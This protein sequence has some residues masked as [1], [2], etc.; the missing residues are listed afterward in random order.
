MRETL[1][2]ATLATSLATRLTD[3][4]LQSWIADGTDVTRTEDGLTFTFEDVEDA[5][6][7]WISTPGFPAMHIG[8]FEDAQFIVQ[9]L[10]QLNPYTQDSTWRYEASDKRKAA[11]NA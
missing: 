8:G 1:T 4:S 11:V 7:F 5:D 3:W 9:Y 2:A 10:I 6:F